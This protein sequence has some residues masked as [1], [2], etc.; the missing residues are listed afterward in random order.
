[1]TDLQTTFS[2]N[3]VTLV[4]RG[5]QPQQLNI[6]SMLQ[7]F[8]AF[9]REVVLRRSTY[10]LGKAK[11][12]LHILEGLKRAIDQIDAII[13][14]IKASQTKQE[15]K[16]KLMSEVFDFSDPQAEYILQMR[17]QSLVGLEIQ[18]IIDEIKEKSELVTELTE[19]IENP[20][21]RD[22]VIKGELEELKDTYGDERRTEVSDDLSIYAL[23]SSMKHLRDAQDKIKESVILWIGNDHTVR[24][25][26]QS[27]INQ[28]PE[29]SL[30]VI[31]THNQDRLIVITDQ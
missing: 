21:R 18:N 23:G 12:R 1:M 26:Y 31:Y 27:R 15:A 22:E 16:Q 7:E 20:V 28:I 30:D 3:N 4:D 2:V 9:R 24:N 29:E 17:L 6:I 11:D 19:I 14:A 13:D 10:L 25:L 8:V 5:I